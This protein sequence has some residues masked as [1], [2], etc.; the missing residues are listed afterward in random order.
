VKKLIRLADLYQKFDKDLPRKNYWEK[1][2][3]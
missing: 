1:L 2:L 3:N